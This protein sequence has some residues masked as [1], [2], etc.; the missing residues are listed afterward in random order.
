MRT[1]S[2]AAWLFLAAIAAAHPGHDVSEE[3]AE[4]ATFLGNI[5][6]AS[7]GHCAEKLKARG[8]EERNSR[9]R[10]ALVEAVREK[11]K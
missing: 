11:R 4:R 5:K 2:S 7:L 8:I 1:S 9:R 3:L 6:R 10:A